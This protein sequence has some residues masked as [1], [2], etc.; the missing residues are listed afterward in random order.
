MGI[1]AG[2]IQLTADNYSSPNNRLTFNPSTRTLHSPNIDVTDITA[3]GDLTVNSLTLEDSFQYNNI[4]LE[5]TESIVSGRE[6][7]IATINIADYKDLF[8]G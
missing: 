7:T 1:G 4:V 8:I 6:V 5:S 2:Q 3:S